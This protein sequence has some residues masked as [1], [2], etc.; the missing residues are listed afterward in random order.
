MPLEVA[1]D[2]V[3]LVS[4]LAMMP[5]A[6]RR[7]GVAHPPPHVLRTECGAKEQ[8]V[9]AQ[10]VGLVEEAAAYLD[11]PGRAEAKSLPR[12]EALAYAS[13]RESAVEDTWLGA[14]LVIVPAVAIVGSLASFILAIL[15]KVRHERWAWL[16]LPLGAFPAMVAFVAFAEAFL[17]E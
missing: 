10:D 3:E 7:V 15:A 5:V 17:M 9:R 8:L 16:W 1:R 12:I 4:A 2:Q 11:G 6:Q 13:E 14:L